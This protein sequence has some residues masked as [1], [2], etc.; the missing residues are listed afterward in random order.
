MKKLA[1]VLT[2][3]CLTLGGC[4]ANPPEKAAD[5][6]DWQ[7][8]WVTVGGVMGIDSPEGMSLQ[9]NNDTLAADGMYYASWTMGNPIPSTN[10][11]GEE[12]QLYDA[13]IYL[14]LAGYPTESAAQSAVEEWLS[15]AEERYLVDSTKNQDYNGGNFTVMDYSFLS[16]TNPYPRGASA[17]G[18]YGNYAITVELSCGE[19]FQKDALDCLENFLE[20]CH[21]SA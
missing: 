11:E 2:A 19:G 4:A 5:G 9:D 7:E 12:I 13:Q 6:S 20:N 16:E 15:M 3:V 21:Y 8:E 1:A 10:A 17:F 14:L 18:I